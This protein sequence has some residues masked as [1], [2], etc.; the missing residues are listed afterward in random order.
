MVCNLQ[1][2]TCLLFTAS[3]ENLARAGVDNVK[4]CNLTEFKVSFE[5][6]LVQRNVSED[7]QCKA[8]DDKSEHT[9]SRMMSKRLHAFCRLRVLSGV[10]GLVQAQVGC[11]F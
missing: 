8:V 3:C 9:S 4:W 5:P 7:P 10:G 1:V 2:V 11:S 6:Q